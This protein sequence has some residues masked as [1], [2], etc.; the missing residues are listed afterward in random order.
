M[1]VQATGRESFNSRE[2]RPGVARHPPQ[3]RPR[4]PCSSAS[5]PSRL[6]WGGLV[7]RTGGRY[8][9]RGGATPPPRAPRLGWRG[10]YRPL[11]ARV[12]PAASARSGARAGRVG[13]GSEGWGRGGRRCQSRGCT[14]ASAAAEGTP[15][16]PGRLGSGRTAPPSSPPPVPAPLA[17]PTPSP[18]PPPSLL[19]HPRSPS[20]SPPAR[21]QAPAAASLSPGAGP[22]RRAGGRADP[23]A[24]KWPP[25]ARSPRVPGEGGARGPGQQPR[26]AG[27]GA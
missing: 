25:G 27:A 13:A 17:S 15:R 18:V 16:P 26:G 11:A 8:Q 24:M 20:L 9:S 1:G 10:W 2:S 3:P 19:P 7:C 21:S 4:S 22:G 6:V 23:A 5:N 14:G 12:P